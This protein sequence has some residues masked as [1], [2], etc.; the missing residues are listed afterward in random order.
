MGPE[1]ARQTEAAIARRARLW[2]ITPP[3]QNQKA[4]IS[5]PVKRFVSERQPRQPAIRVSVSFSFEPGNWPDLIDP[6]TKRKSARQI[7]AE[8]ALKHG[9]KMS[10][11]TGPYRHKSIVKA[12]HEAMWRVRDETNLS[13][14]QIG[15]VLGNRDHTTVLHG[16][17][18][19]GR[20]REAGL[21]DG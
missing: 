12:R 10:D 18:K 7:V 19:H 21:A 16:V 17:R 20:V 11:L 5:R 2:G 13:Y 9:L 3:Q 6:F 4:P 14:P 1:L 15:R 8:V